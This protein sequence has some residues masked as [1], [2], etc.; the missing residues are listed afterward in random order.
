MIELILILMCCYLVSVLVAAG[1]NIIIGTR[2]PLGFTDFMKLTFLP[3]V[4]YY[5]IYDK[6]RLGDI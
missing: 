1:L 3:Y 6:E 2:I 4:V 5:A